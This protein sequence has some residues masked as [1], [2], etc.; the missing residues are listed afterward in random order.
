[1]ETGRK[2][3]ITAPSSCHGINEAGAHVVDNVHWVG[4]AQ[5]EDGLDHRKLRRRRVQTAECGPVVDHHARAYDV[6][7]AVDCPGHEGDL[8]T[9]PKER[10]LIRRL[11][12]K[13]LSTLTNQSQRI[14]E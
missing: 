13:G 11:G 14:W 1:M 12:F 7:P 4:V 2:P 3:T 5:L 8:Q 10:L 6:T 9:R